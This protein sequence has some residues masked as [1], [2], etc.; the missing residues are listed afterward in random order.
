M[1][2][3]KASSSLQPWRIPSSPLLLTISR[4]RS[5]FYAPLRSTINFSYQFCTFPYTSIKLKPLGILHSKKK[6]SDSEPVLESTIVQEVSEDEE[7][8]VDDDEFEYGM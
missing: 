4:S 8:E 7:E 5:S 2:L 6:N 1:D 3:I